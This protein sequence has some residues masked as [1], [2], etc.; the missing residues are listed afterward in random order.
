[1][2][3]SIDTINEKYGT[4]SLLRVDDDG[5]YHRRAY[6]PN[7]DSSDLP[8]TIQIPIERLWTPEAIEAYQELM[9]A[10]NIVS[11]Q[12]DTQ[13]DLNEKINELEAKIAQ[14]ESLVDSLIS[15]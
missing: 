10:N 14:L 15:K 3:Y 6:V 1:M 8:V 5:N 2:E 13:P 7:D 11:E 4:C 12:M 9:D